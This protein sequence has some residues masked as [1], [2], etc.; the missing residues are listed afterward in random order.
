MLLT[1]RQKRRMTSNDA[2]TIDFCSS[3]AQCVE[4]IKKTPKKT[5]CL[6][7]PIVSGAAHVTGGSEAEPWIPISVTS[8]RPL[9][10]P[11]SPTSTSGTSNLHHKWRIPRWTII[12]S[13]RRISPYCLISDSQLQWKSLHKNKT[14]S[15]PFAK[16][17]LGPEPQQSCFKLYIENSLSGL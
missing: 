11:S 1:R 8:C 13:W 2:N 15:C 3:M 10:E 17:W 4:A 16:I 9:P 12:C 7:F 5:E 14:N 6:E